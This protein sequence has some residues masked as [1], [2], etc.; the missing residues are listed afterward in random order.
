MGAYGSGDADEARSRAIL[1]RIG[2]GDEGALGELYALYAPAVLAFAAA[3]TLDRCMAEEVAAD[4]WLGCWHSARA[5]RGDSRVLTWLLGI[6]KRQ[7]CQRM[8]GKRLTELP[9]DEAVWSVADGEAGPEDRAMDEAGV[10]ELLAA[11]DE[12]PGELAETVRLAWLH[13]LPYEEIAV[14]TDVPAGTV[15]SRVFRARCL[16]RDALRRRA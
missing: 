2:R 3:R 8:R 16:L 11:L 15:K 12:L 10:D 7:A 6:V 1:A 5:F 9:L 14:I 13:E 4:A